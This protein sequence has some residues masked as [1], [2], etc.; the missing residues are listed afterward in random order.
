[1][2]SLVS[3]FMHVLGSTVHSSGFEHHFTLSSLETLDD[4]PPESSCVSKLSA[5]SQF[6]KMCILVEYTSLLSSKRQ[7][8]VI[9]R[10]AQGKCLSLLA[11]FLLELSPLLFSIVLRLF[12]PVPKK[13]KMRRLV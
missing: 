2:V 8:E 1:M 10:L 12:Y 9:H 7:S 3:M 6:C 13:K 4:L 11:P 5:V